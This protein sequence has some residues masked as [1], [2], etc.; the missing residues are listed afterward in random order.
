MVIGDK[1]I[2]KNGYTGTITNIWDTGQI[3]VL[4]KPHVTCTYDNEKQLEVLSK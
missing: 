1:V 3:Q 4:Q 2:D